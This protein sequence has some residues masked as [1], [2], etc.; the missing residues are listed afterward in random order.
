M[1]KMLG[2]TQH[3]GKQLYTVLH[4]SRFVIPL[5]RK[6]R[7]F[8]YYFWVHQNLNGVNK[9]HLLINSGI[10]CMDISHEQ[11]SDLSGMLQADLKQTFETCRACLHCAF[12]WKT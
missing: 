8:H 5:I 2:C 10:A 6:P 3:L 11:S 9:G 7:G 12:C 4:G 1:W